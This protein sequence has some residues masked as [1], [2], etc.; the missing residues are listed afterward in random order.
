VPLTHYCRLSNQLIYCILTPPPGLEDHWASFRNMPLPTKH[1]A[2][3]AH[4][5]TRV[6]QIPPDGM[7]RNSRIKEICHDGL[8]AGAPLANLPQHASPQRLPFFNACHMLVIPADRSPI[9]KTTR[10]HK[11]YPI[12][13]ASYRATSFRVF[14]RNSLKKKKKK[15]GKPSRNPATTMPPVVHSH[16]PLAARA[17]FKHASSITRCT[18]TA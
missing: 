6:D 17:R 2:S 13:F 4:L 8:Y 5:I 9:L 12:N 15:K 11:P 1:F 3:L 16:T 10:P 7:R 18:V 14:P